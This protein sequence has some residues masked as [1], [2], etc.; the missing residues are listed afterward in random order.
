MAA[1]VYHIV[2]YQGH[3][4]IEFEGLYLGEFA[5]AAAAGETALR[6][7][8]SRLAPSPST[9]IIIAPNGEIIIGDLEDS[10]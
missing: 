4:R 2:F 8:R 10:T 5:T 1:P 3:S 7:A 6:I 9:Q